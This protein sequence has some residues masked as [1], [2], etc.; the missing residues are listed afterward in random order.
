MGYVLP[1]VGFW[2]APYMKILL[3]SLALS[4]DIMFHI[5]LLDSITLGKRVPLTANEINHTFYIHVAQTGGNMKPVEGQCGKG[6][7]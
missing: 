4:V 7:C 6:R 1:S 3:G 2:G 5:I